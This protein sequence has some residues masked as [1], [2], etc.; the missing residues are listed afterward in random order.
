MRRSNRETAPQSNN[1]GNGND[2]IWQQLQAIF[3]Q[4]DD[5]GDA[6]AAD[7]ELAEP[8]HHLRNL[9]HLHQQARRAEHHLRRD[10]QQ[11]ESLRL[12]RHTKV[13]ALASLAD[14][15]R[16]SDPRLAHTLWRSLFATA[17][18]PNDQLTS[19]SKHSRPTTPSFSDAIAHANDGDSKILGADDSHSHSDPT[20]TQQRLLV[21]YGIESERTSPNSQSPQ[22]FDSYVSGTSQTHQLSLQQ[23]EVHSPPR[24]PVA[25]R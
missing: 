2:A 10:R 14:Q 24:S 16:H 15:H 21:E 1:G 17:I 19:S 25:Q 6:A 18:L 8:L 20:T 22:E 12:E 9:L 3:A 23:H 5:E 4:M 13:D 11:L 7:A